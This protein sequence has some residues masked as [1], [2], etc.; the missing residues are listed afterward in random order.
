MSNFTVGYFY[1]KLLNLYGDRGN[2]EIL[3]HR[4]KKRGLN[5]NVVEITKD[6]T[7]TTNLMKSLDVIVMGG[8][9]DSAQKEMY[10]DL[11]QKKGVFL[12]DYILSGGVGLYVCGSYQLLGKYYKAADGSIL[13]GL[14]ILD[15]YTKHPG[16]KVARCIG[17]TVCKLNTDI[18]EDEVFKAV[19]QLGDTLVGFENHGG[20]TYLGKE[21]RSL[22]EVIKGHGNNLDDGGEGLFYKNTLATYFHGPFLSKNAHIAD[23]LIAKS[24]G[25]DKLRLEKIDLDT[26]VVA[27]HYNMLKR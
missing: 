8:G 23:F 2:V 5:A 16:K 9:P 25:L 7:L 27:A 4:A 6:T 15:F 22:A 10:E 18:S 3:I 17:N 12:K 1:P 13:D 26:F 21:L 11:M 24:V 20:R 14:N 19:S